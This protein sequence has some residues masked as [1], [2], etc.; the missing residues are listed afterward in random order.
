[1]RT[2]MIL[3]VLALASV[4]RTSAATGAWSCVNELVLPKY[5]SL[6]RQARIEGTV[7]VFVEIGAKGDHKASIEPGSH[8]LLRQAVEK[9][10]KDAEFNQDCASRNVT[11]D[12]VFTID[13]ARKP[14]T[15]DDGELAIKAPGEVIIKAA[16]FPMTGKTRV[17]AGVGWPL[18]VVSTGNHHRKAARDAGEP[19]QRTDG[20]DCNKIYRF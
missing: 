18:L 11:L 20:D 1:M 16:P 9:S 2:L 7:R 10:L 4:S 5:P 3:G 13:A 12:F 14:R 17:P 15:A 6:A 19:L 8:K